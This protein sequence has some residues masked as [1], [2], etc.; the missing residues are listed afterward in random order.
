LSINASGKKAEVY[1]PIG[2]VDSE[3]DDILFLQKE[4]DALDE[5]LKT[6]LKRDSNTKI[7]TKEMTS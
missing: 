1:R 2:S 6:D 4:Q 3:E 5:R 7:I